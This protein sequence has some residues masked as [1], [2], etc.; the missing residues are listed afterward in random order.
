MFRNNFTTSWRQILRNK[1]NFLFRVGGLTL[2]L[3]GLLIIALYV[4]YHLSFDRYHD[5]YQKIYRVNSK[6]MENGTLASYEDPAI[7]SPRGTTLW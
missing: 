3:S 4:S 1:V 7:L 2:A 5:D 6:W